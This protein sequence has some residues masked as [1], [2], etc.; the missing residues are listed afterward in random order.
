MLMVV[1]NS[2]TDSTLVNL[3]FTMP[4]SEVYR[5]DWMAQHVAAAQPD[6][7]TGNDERARNVRFWLAPG[8]MELFKVPHPGEATDQSKGG[9]A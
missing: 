8:Q 5:V 4:R 7:F 1:N 3:E 6:P 2:Q 9:L